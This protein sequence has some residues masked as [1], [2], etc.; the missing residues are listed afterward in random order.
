MRWHQYFRI[1]A[2]LSGML[3]FDQGLKVILLEIPK[4][5]SFLL[6]QHTR[7]GSSPT[8]RGMKSHISYV[9]GKKSMPRWRRSRK[10]VRTEEQVPTQSE[11]LNCYTEILVFTPHLFKCGQVY[12]YLQPNSKKTR[13]KRQE[14]TVSNN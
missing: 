12:K 7:I 1:I 6:F 10:G 8:R 14:A 4:G 9:K 3:H 11:R 2:P 5:W 13:E